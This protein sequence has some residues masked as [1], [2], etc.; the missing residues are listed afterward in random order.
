VGAYPH[1]APRHGL[2]PV[3]SAAFSGVAQY[4]LRYHPC[5]PSALVTFT[6]APML[7][8]SWRIPTPPS[9]ALSPRRQPLRRANAHPCVHHSRAQPRAAPKRPH[10]SPG[11]IDPAEAATCLIY[12]HPGH[13]L[14]YDNVR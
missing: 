1:P 13:L 9:G 11:K 4:P 8:R 6:R 7:R 14:S 3:I 12:A 10:G 2:P 5:R